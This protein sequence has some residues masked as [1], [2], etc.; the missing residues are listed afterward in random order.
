MR[1]GGRSVDRKEN[2]IRVIT[3]NHSDHVPWFLTMKSD[4]PYDEGSFQRLP[5]EGAFPP[6]EGGRDVW[7]V[8]WQASDARL[9]LPYPLKHPLADLT[10]LDD[11]PWPDP[12]DPRLLEPVRREMDPSRLML[13]THGL[14]LM[15]RAH[16]LMGMD[17][18][19]LALMADPNRVKLLLR[20]ITDFQIRT[21]QHFVRLGVDGGWFSD[22]YGSQSSML[23]SPAT[24]REF[25]KPLLAEIIQVYK[26]VGLFV[27]F[28]SCGHVEPIVPDLIEIGV[29]VLHPAQK[30][31]NDQVGL[32]REYGDQIAF[33]GGMDTQ[34]TL[35]LGTPEEVRAE[36]LEQ[37]AVLGQGGGYIAGPENWPPFPPENAKAF[38]TVV[39]KYGKYPLRTDLLD[40][41][42]KE[43]GTR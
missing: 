18:L 11:Y 23:I 13:G 29:D 10:A 2:L 38:A 35:T 15:E 17:N 9:M 4:D 24:F 19:F 3:F 30:R 12:D 21:A 5:Y 1:M 6:R 7:G 22:D 20:K 33:A 16:S 40:L 25:F 27:F 42:Q 39:S 36:A 26:R 28:H 32:K 31:A 37:I 41:A 8:E 14:T 34:Y 43:E